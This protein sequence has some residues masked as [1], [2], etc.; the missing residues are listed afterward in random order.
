MTSDSLDSASD[1]GIIQ[2]LLDTETTIL[3]FGTR[4]DVQSY[5]ASVRGLRA[6]CASPDSTLEEICDW[7]RGVSYALGS[8]VTACLLR[9]SERWLWIPYPNPAARKRFACHDDYT[10]V[11]ASDAGRVVCE[12]TKQ[13]IDGRPMVTVAF[14]VEYAEN[15]Q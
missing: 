5:L 14:R 12:A 8:S 11:W 4:I 15:L 1:L 7:W 13:M 10:V 3:A 6:A 2:A 9:F